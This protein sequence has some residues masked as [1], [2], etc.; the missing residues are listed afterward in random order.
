MQQNSGAYMSSQ[1]NVVPSHGLPPHQSQNYAARPV[2]PNGTQAQ[3]FPQTPAFAGSAQV[4][5]MQFTGN[6]TMTNQNYGPRTNNQMHVVSEQHF[7]SGLTSHP[8]GAERQGDHMPGKSLADQK[9]WITL[10]Q[11]CSKR[12]KWFGFRI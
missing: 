6:Q 3:V 5:P 1:Q 12:T 9:K 11:N 2:M 10:S 4:R 7:Q 8:T